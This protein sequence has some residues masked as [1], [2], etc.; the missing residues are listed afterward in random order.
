[1]RQ[2]QIINTFFSHCYSKD[3]ILSQLEKLESEKIIKKEIYNQKIF[4]KKF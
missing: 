2:D 4:W 1:M 3:V